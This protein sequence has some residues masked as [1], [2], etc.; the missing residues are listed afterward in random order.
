MPPGRTGLRASKDLQQDSSGDSST[1][2][3]K[4]ERHGDEMGEGMS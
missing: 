1:V 2:V 3:S 4:Q